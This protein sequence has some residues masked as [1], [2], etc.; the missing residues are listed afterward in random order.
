MEKE[1]RHL[2][3][4]RLEVKLDGGQPNAR[5]SLFGRMSGGAMTELSAEHFEELC[6]H[7]PVRA[8]MDELETRRKEAIGA[9]WKRSAVTVI[10]AGA[11]GVG[12]WAVHNVA[13]FFVGILALTGGLIWAYQPIHHAQQSLKLPVLQALAARIGMQYHQGDFAPPV[14]G[15]AG[16][17]LFGRWARSST[18]SDLFEGEDPDGFAYAFYEACITRRIGKNT[19]QIF[20][21]QIY[22][23]EREGNPKALTVIL[24]DKGLFN[25]FKPGPGMER[26]GFE[27][28]DAFEHMFEVYSTHPAD[29]KAMLASPAVRDRLRGAR[30]EGWTKRLLVYLSPS[31]GFV[32][33][34]GGNRFEPGTMFRSRP[35]E[36]RVRRMFDEVCGSLA[37][38]KQFRAAFG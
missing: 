27:G 2:G 4:R 34:Q 24:P 7:G 14:F 37:L 35:S 16:P 31:H 22:A 1:A 11:L 3:K 13:G 32:A 5:R 21:G 36:E 10:A 25:L 17:S 9:F 15:E 19:Q 28:D 26:V 12:L 6:R 20:S 33:V 38:L 8:G 18:F 30:G 23:F 29:A